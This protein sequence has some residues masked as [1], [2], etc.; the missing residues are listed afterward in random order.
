MGLIHPL[1]LDFAAAR[2]IMARARD[3]GFWQIEPAV[4]KKVL[5]GEKRSTIMIFP[6]PVLVI[7]CFRKNLKNKT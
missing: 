6:M 7:I 5:V 4:D 2:P 3:H 1:V